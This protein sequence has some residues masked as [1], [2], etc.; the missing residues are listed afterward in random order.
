MGFKF[1]SYRDPRVEGTFDDF[2]QSV[3]WLLSQTRRQDELVE[4]ATLG[5]IGSLDRPGSPAGEAKQAYHMERGGR[6]LA[7][8]QQYRERLLGTTWADVQRVTEQYLQEQNGSLA[9]IAPRG[10]QATADKLGLTAIDF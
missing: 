2:R 1:Y 8:R 7:M 10:T 9:V 5:L 4:Q 3:D 6:N